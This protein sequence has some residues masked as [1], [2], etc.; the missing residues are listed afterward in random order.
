MILSTSIGDF[1]KSNVIYG[2]EWHTK[3]T[4]YQKDNHLIIGYYENSFIWV[5]FVQL[6]L[7]IGDIGDL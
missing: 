4:Y 5:I 7:Y 6:R 3:Y 1:F 2:R